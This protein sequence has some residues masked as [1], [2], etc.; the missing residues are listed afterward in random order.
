MVAQ[1]T[2]SKCRFEI[3]PN[4]HKGMVRCKQDDTHLFT[5]ANGIKNRF[6]R[7]EGLYAGI[8]DGTLRQRIKHCMY[9]SIALPVSIVVL[10]VDEG[11]QEFKLGHLVLDLLAS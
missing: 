11:V 2:I 7:G 6:G 10:P 1:W 4:L 8:V 9:H 3:V 5:R